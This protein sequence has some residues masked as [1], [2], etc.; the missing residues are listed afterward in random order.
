MRI[1]IM[2]ASSFLGR[3]LLARLEEEDLPYQ[4]TLLS[5]RPVSFSLKHNFLYYHF[6]EKQADIGILKQH[7]AIIY[8][9]GAG[10][11]PG[12]QDD[13]SLVYEMN[14][15]EP[16]RLIRALTEIDYQGQLT[17]F[18]SYFEIGETNEQVYYSESGLATHNNL[19]PNDYCIAK[20]ILTRFISQQLR[21]DKLPFQLAHYVL[22]NMYGPG[23]NAKRL[24]PYLLNCLEQGKDLKLSS[25]EQLRQYTHV[26]DISCFLANVLAKPVHGIY[27]LTYPDV[28]SVRFLVETLRKLVE[29]KKGWTAEAHF[30]EVSRRDLSMR[31]LGLDS[32]KAIDELGWN[33]QID[34][35]QGLKTYL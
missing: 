21:G 28:I 14:A 6:P 29:E 34:I 1:A 3:N 25:G 9:A 27:N 7:D 12:H 11:Q 26:K 32:Q 19:L 10:I 2:G 16:I 18:G 30:G 8:C 23:E 22:T 31:F 17:T 35:E 13:P 4:F 15:F 24:I 33:P 20:N 5:R